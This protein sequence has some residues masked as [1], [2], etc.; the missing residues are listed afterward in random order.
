LF[1]I[2]RIFDSNGKQLS[3]PVNGFKKAGYYTA[4]I[5]G[6]SLPSGVYFIRMESGNFFAVRKMILIK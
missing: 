4:T 2:I 6:A 1:Y 3:E 5:S